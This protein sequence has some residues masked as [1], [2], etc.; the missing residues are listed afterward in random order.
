MTAF[1]SGNPQPASAL[2]PVGAPHIHIIGADD[3]HAVVDEDGLGM[4]GMFSQI[5]VDTDAGGPDLLF[6]VQIVG[7]A[8]GWRRWPHRW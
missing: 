7:A 2:Y 1:N 3:A 8:Q 5:F 6:L 4:A